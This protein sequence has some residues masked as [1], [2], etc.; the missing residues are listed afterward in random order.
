MDKKDS[1]TQEK[2]IV[3]LTIPLTKRRYES[4][5]R[6]AFNKFFFWT[7]KD[8]IK[9]EIVR[10]GY[11]WSEYFDNL[12][13]S[14]LVDVKKKKKKS[15]CIIDHDVT[16][17]NFKSAL[18]SNEF[19]CVILIAHHFR[20]EKTDGIEFANGCIKLNKVKRVLE[21]FGQNKTLIFSVCESDF[22]EKKQKENKL[23]E[24]VGTANYRIKTSPNFSFI[25]EWILQMDGKSSIHESY[26]KAI[27]KHLI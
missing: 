11:S 25:K 20:N 6:R 1:I 21:K 19:S 14:I 15:Q 8:F 2:V 7:Q 26:A 16:F 13:K 23:F 22:L 3:L 24:T 10:L 9:K 4:D 18:K 12:A 27:K 17:S 5:Y